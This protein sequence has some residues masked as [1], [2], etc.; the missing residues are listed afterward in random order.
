MPRPIPQ[1]HLANRLSVKY[2]YFTAVHY[3][4]QSLILFPLRAQP[5]QPK[6]LFLEMVDTVAVE[7]C[8]LL[9]FW[10]TSYRLP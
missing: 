2:L 1:Y 7:W 8:E 9:F 3:T 4:L 10:K 6:T 5:M